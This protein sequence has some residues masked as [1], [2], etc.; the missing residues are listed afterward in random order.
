M[1]VGLE[2][3]LPDGEERW[4]VDEVREGVSEPR[5]VPGLPKEL[6]GVDG[7]LG[8]LLAQGGSWVWDRLVGFSSMLAASAV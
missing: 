3:S 1:H 5:G 8:L 2:H 4:L 6:R 7:M